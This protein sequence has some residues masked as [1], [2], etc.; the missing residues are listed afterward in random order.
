MTRLPIL[1]AIIVLVLHAAPTFAAAPAAPAADT[2]V[3]V[4]AR[5]VAAPAISELLLP[6]TIE[7]WQE[8]LINA[9]T[10]GYVKRWHAELGDEVKAGDLL[11]EIDAPEIDQ[12]LAAAQAAHAQAVA[13]LGLARTTYERWKTLVERKT[14]AAQ[15]L[16][17]RRATFDARKADLL[18]ADAEVARLTELHGFKRVVAPFAGTVTR[19]HVE[20]GALIDAGS[21]AGGELYRVAETKRLRIRVGVPQANLRAIRR[22]LPATVLVAEFPGQPFEGTVVRSAGAIDPATRTLLTEVELPNPDGA[23]LPGLYAQVRFAMPFAG[24]TVLVPTNAIRI[25][26]AGA[27]VATVDAGQTVQL[28]KVELGRNL[29]TQVEVLHGLAPDTPVIL[30]P[31]DLLQDG[32]PVIAREPA[33]PKV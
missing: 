9:R 27:H 21:S 2:P 31:T 23:L 16:D 8:T 10:D 6:G 15:E 12:A 14:V 28:Q 4:I 11:V 20:N 29:G 19:R 30:N 13:N 24:E 26:A 3:V 1:S 33:A 17:E 22:G 32:L 7:A 25:D 18:A 5:A